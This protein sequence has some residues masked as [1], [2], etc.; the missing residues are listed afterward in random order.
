MSMSSSANPPDCNSEK[1]DDV[2]AV[3][4]AKIPEVELLMDVDELLNIVNGGKALDPNETVQ[5]DTKKVQD[6]LT[7]AKQRCFILQ[8][9]DDYTPIKKSD[10][11]PEQR[12]LNK[13]KGARTFHKHEL[14]KFYTNVMNELSKI[15]ANLKPNP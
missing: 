13:Q 6:L 3:L 11:S 4:S 2:A 8:N 1:P 5:E 9:L 14:K 12:K 10:A 15:E 7:K